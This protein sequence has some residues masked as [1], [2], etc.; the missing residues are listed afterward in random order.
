MNILV[1]IPY[2]DKEIEQKLSDIFTV[3]DK[4]GWSFANFLFYA[5]RHNDKDIH[6]M[7]SNNSLH[8][9]K[10]GPGWLTSVSVQIVK[11]RLMI[12]EATNATRSS[13]GPCHSLTQIM[14]EKGR[15]GFFK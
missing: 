12:W 14:P 4:A 9:H 13:S 5:F 7:F 8:R 2:K 11:W 1:H 6:C 3:I 15:V 10:T